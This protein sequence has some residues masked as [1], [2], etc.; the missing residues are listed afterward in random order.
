[1]S[2][3]GAR[4]L[5]AI[6]LQAAALLVLALALLGASWLDPRTRPRVLLLVDRSHGMP[7]AETERAA[8]AVAEAARAQG[9]AIQRIDFAGRAGLASASARTAAATL[10]PA[11]TDIEAALQA[12]LAAHARTRFDRAVIVSDGF[13]TA[14]DTE[15]GLRALRAAGLPLQWIA[16][17]R[18]PPA[19]SIA[20]VLAPESAVAGQRAR[21]TVRLAG[22]IGRPLR[23]DA[24]ARSIDGD[25]QTAT[26]ETDGR[27]SVAIDFDARG[28]EALVV[29]VALRDPASG[30]TIAALADAAVIAVAPPAAILYVQGS[31][32]TRAPLARSL[33]RGGWKLDVVPAASLDG[34]AGRLE[35]YRAVILDDIA[36]GDAGPRLWSA[37]A[38]AVR[39]R[40]VGL[41]VLG[42]ERSFAR[43]GYRDSTLESVLPVASTPQALDQP[44]SVVFAVDK[45]GSMGRGSGGVDRFA[46][47]RRAVIASARAL[48][49]GDAL[50]L[51]V[52]DVQARMLIPIRPAAAAIPVLERDWPAT[53]GGGTRIEPA[54]DTAIDALERAGS[55]RR[56]LVLVTDGFVGDAPLARLRARLARARIETIAIA[57]GPD[58]DAAALQRL[59]GAG[60][61][62]VLRVDEAAELP[63]AMRSGIERL[64][65][66]VERGAI[67]VRQREPLPFAPATFADWPAVAAYAVTRARAEA[68]VAVQS[69]RGEPLIAYRRAGRG[70]VAAVTCGLGPW[71]PRWL[72][73]RGWPR[74]AGG[75]AGWVS[76]ESAG[77][78]LT[79]TDRPEGLEIQAETDDG[80][81]TAGPGAVSIAV[82]TPTKPAVTLAAEAFAPGLVRAT[83][84]D[85]GPGVY[86]VVMTTAR[87]AT[88][89]RLHLR[90]Q[91]GED[92][93][94]GTNPQIE[95]WRRAGLISDGV[96]SDAARHREGTEPHRRPL[97]RSLV[98]L[99]LALVLGGVMADR[100]RLNPPA[101]ARV[102]RLVS[103]R[104]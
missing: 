35:A 101:L 76:G 61:G 12:A 72:T 5:V 80:A 51:L 31:T 64:R 6:A 45:S 15:R 33:M 16:L 54:L 85:A 27:D 74:L 28:G 95:G 18:A 77:A 19:T 14:G 81:A 42:G 75:L 1:M 62:A 47:A 93:R 56:M 2:R 29:D 38:A 11:A 100:A 8:R 10:D 83:L 86:T 82:D 36:I 49:A 55:G 43:G 22:Q 21:I 39:E 88:R 67:A 59:V 99:G 90:R 7:A 63:V 87:G 60:A 79:V 4:T 84:P 71:A 52:F 26:R 73:W 98:A 96:G 103:R 30:Q 37:L 66:R 9:A 48:G 44:A 97:D 25:T 94:W 69:E 13:A 40:G 58:A 41:L 91:R 17:G 65:A 102:R 89:T 92:E 46:L 23:V 24:T 50:G 3:T 57:V 70:R 53:P 20:E 104:R 78:S 68:N 32:E 34:L